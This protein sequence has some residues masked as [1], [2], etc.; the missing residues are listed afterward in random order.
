MQ[1]GKID[2]NIVFEAVR[3]YRQ[4]CSLLEAIETFL[5]PLLDYHNIEFLFREDFFEPILDA[6]NDEL[7]RFTVHRKYQKDDWFGYLIIKIDGSIVLEKEKV[8]E[9]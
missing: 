7:M 3:I 5:S 1:V 4:A 6:Q 9:G 8:E 2:P